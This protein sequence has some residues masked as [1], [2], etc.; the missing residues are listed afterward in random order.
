MHYDYAL[1]GVKRADQLI[2]PCDKSKC[3]TP[4]VM[5]MTLAVAFSMPP[6]TLAAR[7][8]RNADVT[9]NMAASVRSSSFDHS[10]KDWESKS[11]FP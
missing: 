11:A 6:F 9:K 10:S 3:V 2:R 7:R 8:P 1:R 5:L 4:L